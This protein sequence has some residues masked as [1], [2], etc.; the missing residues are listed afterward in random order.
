MSEHTENEM[1]TACP[2][3]SVW[4]D[5]F[6][7]R[8]REVA[9]D[10]Q[11]HTHLDGCTSC[12]SV[13]DAV[14]RYQT[15]LL[16][17][18]APGLS[19]EQRQSLD[20]RVHLMS[21]RWQKPPRVSPGFVW[22][23]ALATAAALVFTV[24]KPFL[25]KSHQNQVAFQQLV[26]DATAPS[27]DNPGPGVVTSLV[28]GDV[29][30]AAQDGKWRKLTGGDTI[31]FGNRL[32]TQKAPSPRVARVVVPGRFELTLAA[33]TELDVLAM[34][35]R[36]A[37]LRLRHGEVECQV[38]KLKAGQRYGVMFAGFRASV[39]GTRFVVRHDD[40]DSGVVV[41]VTEGA[42][43]VDQ[44]DDPYAQPGD[45]LT[46]VRAGNRWQYIGGR[47]ALEPIPAAVAIPA[48]NAAPVVNAAQPV[49]PVEPAVAPVEVAPVESEAPAAQPAAVGASAP[50]VRAVV[51]AAE[52]PVSAEP[53]V[54]AERTFNFPAATA[55]QP[56]AIVIEVP[57]QQMPPPDQMA[58]QPSS[59][60][61][62][63]QPGFER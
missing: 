4:L 47:M 31:R 60:R 51:R 52:R 34:A 57:P 6:D 3:S 45:T 10:A 54:A 16:R 49:A 21:G 20:E 46:M 40:N 35:D 13:A 17:G 56:H 37:F 38:E 55:V 42:V 32:R 58:V 15:L 33:D 43:R 9:A 26:V 27:V 19:A 11:L 63:E 12:Q 53:G 22:G 48:A 24:A 39:M 41:Q 50:S 2:D 5:L 62:A 25:E 59:Q 44:A 28:E 30:V 36:D 8:H 23:L 14:R 29:E 61:R 18:R 1:L 7:A